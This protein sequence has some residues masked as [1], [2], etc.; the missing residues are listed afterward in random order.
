[1]VRPQRRASAGSAAPSVGPARL[2]MG[3]RSLGRRVLGDHLRGWQK[4]RFVAEAWTRTVCAAR[5]N[6]ARHG[7]ARGSV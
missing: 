1:M 2:P 7:P 6:F 5:R 3:L 4:L